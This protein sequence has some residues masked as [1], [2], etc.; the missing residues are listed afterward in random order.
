MVKHGLITMENHSVIG[1][2][3]SATAEVLAEHAVAKPLIRLGVPGG[4]YAHGASREYLVKEYGFDADALIEAIEKLV[5]RK[6][7]RDMDSRGYQQT[8]SQGQEAN[9]LERPED[10]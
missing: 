6:L 4:T 8:A 7:N 2:V 3:G 9:L 10:L 1:G 5:G